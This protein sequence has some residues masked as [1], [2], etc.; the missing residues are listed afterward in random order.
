M[1]SGEVQK[2]DPCGLRWGSESRGHTLRFPCVLTQR[3]EP[4]TGGGVVIEQVYK[5]RE[6]WT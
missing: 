2:L 6:R 3:T 5:E 1:G 4:G